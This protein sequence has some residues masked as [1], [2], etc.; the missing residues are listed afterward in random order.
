MKTT[1]ITIALAAIAVATEVTPTDLNSNITS[2]PI[3]IAL[4][5]DAIDTLKSHGLWA[6]DID[7]FGR[8]HPNVD[9]INATAEN[10]KFAASG[11]NLQDLVSVHVDGH[12]MSTAVD[13]DKGFA[14]TDVCAPYATGLFLSKHGTYSSG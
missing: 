13:G 12:A 7:A 11:L 14:N 3:E 9:N 5:A 8:G 10:L 1:T 2:L 4:A 6:P